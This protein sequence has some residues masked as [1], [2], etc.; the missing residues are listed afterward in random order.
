MNFHSR[1]G[2]PARV[3]AAPDSTVFGLIHQGVSSGF[4]L[5]G[6]LTCVNTATATILVSF[7]KVYTAGVCS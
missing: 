6:D 7:N 1:D 5:A 4:F 3:N 2:E